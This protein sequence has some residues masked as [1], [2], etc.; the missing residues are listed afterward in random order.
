MRSSRCSV[1]AGRVPALR[2]VLLGGLLGAAGAA[3]PAGFRV[4]SGPPRNVVHADILAGALGKRMWGLSYE[5]TREAKGHQSLVWGVGWMED[6]EAGAEGGADVPEVKADLGAAGFQFR[7]YRHAA[8]RGFFT[9]MGLSLLVGEAAGED[10]EEMRRKYTVVA[11]DVSLLGFGYQL[12]L[13]NRLS[14]EGGAS[15]HTALG[16]LFEKGGDDRGTVGGFG[17]G[18]AGSVG[19]AF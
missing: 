18:V 3:E 13:G 17:V 1:L 9:V 5:R 15:L 16:G 11:Y 2:I 7:Y 8:P 4:D 14:I 10:M 12:L 6:L 19:L